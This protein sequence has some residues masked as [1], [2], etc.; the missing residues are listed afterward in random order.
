MQVLGGGA[1]DK[2]TDIAVV[3]I[4]A[5]LKVSDFDTMDLAYAPPFS[6]AIHPFVQACYVLQN[7]LSGALETFTPA[8]Y[9]AGKAKDYR[10]IDVQPEAKIFGA[11]WVDLAKVNGELPGI[12]KEEKLLLVCTRGKRGYFLQN[13]LKYYGYTNTKVLEGGA[14]FN[15][16]KV[17]NPTGTLSASEIKRV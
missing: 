7:K 14:F 3:G 17:E 12:G 8:E 11:T 4:S 5:G 2:M 16:V 1:V 15:A 6:T 10:V 13:R 9:L